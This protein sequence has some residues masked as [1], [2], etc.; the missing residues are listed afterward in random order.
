MS[1]TETNI[2]NDAL[3]IVISYNAHQ[4]SYNAYH[5]KK[6]GAESARN[7]KIKEF[8]DLLDTGLKENNIIFPNDRKKELFSRILRVMS[9]EE[10]VMCMKQKTVNDKLLSHFNSKLKKFLLSLKIEV[11][12][13]P[14]NKRVL[15][16][17]TN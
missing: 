6:K 4:E 3:E 10:S 17:K 9:D 1:E 13:D 12:I 11:T 15:L 2:R 7:K 8:S 14:S 5:Q 16:K